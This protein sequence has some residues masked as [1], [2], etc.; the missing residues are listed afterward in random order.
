M[1]QL[2]CS[3]LDSGVCPGL[4]GFTV[5][6]CSAVNVILVVH[7][8]LH[9]C[10]QWKILQL[11]KTSSLFDHERLGI[12][13][14]LKYKVEMPEIEEK[15]REDLGFQRYNL[16]KRLLPC[17]YFFLFFC[18]FFKSK[19]SLTYVCVCVESWKRT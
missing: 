12:S 2:L 10:S 11:N 14:L 19:S 4:A 16:L 1:I 17:N 18:F 5:P 6:R 8:S 3:D 7:G 13:Y 9:F 15:N